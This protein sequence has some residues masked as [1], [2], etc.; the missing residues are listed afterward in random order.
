MVKMFFI[1]TTVSINAL[2]MITKREARKCLRTV[3]ILNGMIKI[4]ARSKLVCAA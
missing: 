2:K 4:L 1:L 3:E